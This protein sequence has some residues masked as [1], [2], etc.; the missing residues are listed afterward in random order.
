MELKIS[1][2]SDRIF[3]FVSSATSITGKNKAIKY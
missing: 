3:D 1:S 2:G